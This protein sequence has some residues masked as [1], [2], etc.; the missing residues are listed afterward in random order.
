MKLIRNDN[1][2]ML[3]NNKGI[4]YPYNKLNIQYSGPIV[5]G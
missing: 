5:Y 2:I 3:N 4:I 1:K